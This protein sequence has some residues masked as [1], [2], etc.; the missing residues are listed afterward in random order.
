MTDNATRAAHEKAVSKAEK[1][2]AQ[3][4]VSQVRF[5]ESEVGRGLQLQLCPTYG[6]SLLQLCANT[7][8]G[9]TCGC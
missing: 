1:L 2:R 4:E 8:S 7:C 9:R 6:C 3:L 5:D